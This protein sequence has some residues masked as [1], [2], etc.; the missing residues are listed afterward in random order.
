MKAQANG[1]GLLYTRI[2]GGL[3]GRKGKGIYQL[4]VEFGKLMLRPFRAKSILII[5]NPGRWPGLS[6]SAPLALHLL[7][8]GN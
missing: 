6:P 2:F 8:E 5:A 1:L 4:E 7:S 3:K